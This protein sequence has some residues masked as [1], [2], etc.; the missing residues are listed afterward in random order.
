MRHRRGAALLLATAASALKLP[1]RRLRQRLR[2]ATLD[3]TPENT[4]DAT[5]E[6][7]DPRDSAINLALLDEPLELP[8]TP[9]RPKILA[10]AAP[11]AVLNLANFIM[12]SVDTAAVGTFGTTTQLAALAPGTM[13]MEYSCYALSFL[14]TASLNLLS[15]ISDPDGDERDVWDSTLAGSIKVAI[16]V[17]LVHGG[18]LLGAAAPLA[19]LLGANG[20]TVA[21]AARYL[22]LRAASAIAFHV[23]AVCGAAHFA[24]K[25]SKTPL[26]T[27]L[28][29]GLAN[30]F[31]DR[32]L[33]PLAES[34]RLPGIPDA[35][36][37][38]ALATT[39]AQFLGLG[40]TLLALKQTKRLPRV[41]AR[42]GT[43]TT[44]GAFLAFA[45]PVSQ[46]LWC[47][48]AIYAYV[49]RCASL[50]GA[51]AGAAQQIM[52]TLFW[53]STTLSA[54]PFNT[55]GQTFLPDHYDPE[56]PDVITPRF[57]LTL[58]RLLDSSLLWGLAIT[59]GTWPLKSEKALSAFT[60]SKE[61]MNLVAIGPILAVGAIIAPMLTAEGTLVVLGEF[62]WL[63]RSMVFSSFVTYG[64]VTWLRNAG[65]A[66]IANYWW[67]T[68][69]F[70]ACRLICNMVGVRT[71][72]RRAR[73]KN[74]AEYRREKREAELRL[75]TCP[76][77]FDK[78]QWVAKHKV[79]A[80]GRSYPM[81][82]EYERIP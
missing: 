56:T 69:T 4:W 5:D 78:K 42:R 11:V 43:G 19:R 45:G 59:L 49:G 71:H 72:V 80:T 21:P 66:S 31:G 20:V 53:G 27:I 36:G 51:A 61:V 10:F 23:S 46:L 57:R 12:G 52:S 24:K 81:D 37:A 2:A 38:A 50:L 15:T 68:V 1:G 25:D 76:P 18:L 16:L 60:T 3:P 17:G 62:Q 32:V 8:E 55:A 63:V 47:R 30:C 58:Q 82:I 39:A 65:R 26:Y 44:S 9:S 79:P 74:F 73:V 7:Y 33:C 14:T 54:E 75:R 67:A 28:F 35:I 70:T 48:I 22:R 41:W 40:F 77:W 6:T 13:G 34:G 29:A 64:L